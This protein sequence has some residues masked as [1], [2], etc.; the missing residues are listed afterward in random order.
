MKSI[1][2]KLSFLLLIINSVIIHAQEIT[3][4]ADNSANVI[5]NSSLKRKPLG[6]YYGYERSA[7]VFTKEELNQSS[8]ISIQGISFFL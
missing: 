6:S 3:I 7:F 5:T 1:V 2:N 8:A 4:P